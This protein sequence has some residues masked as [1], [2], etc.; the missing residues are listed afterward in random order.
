MSAA[1]FAN[2]VPILLVFRSLAAM[3]GF[4]LALAMLTDIQGPKAV[5]GGPIITQKT[6][7]DDRY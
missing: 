6:L 1:K 5:H 7:D 3:N 4:V 2:C